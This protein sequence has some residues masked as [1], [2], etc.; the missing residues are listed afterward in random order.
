LNVGPTYA[1]VASGKNVSKEHCLLIA[2]SFWNRKEGRVGGRNRNSL[3][4]TKI[5]YAG[6][7]VRTPGS[8]ETLTGFAM[9]T[10][11]NSRDG[12]VITRT[13]TAHVG[14]NLHD[15]SNSLMAHGRTDTIL[16]YWTMVSVQI[17]STDSKTRCSNK[18]TI[19]GRNLSVWHVLKLNALVS[20][21][22]EGSHGHPPSAYV[23]ARHGFAATLP[24]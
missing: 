8:E 18:S 16:I 13:N 9:A 7:S 6:I 10:A 2:N 17:R 20:A 23:M 21:I 3:S 19:G 4:L 12:N 5:E 22:N 15:L 24:V 14:A 1:L 11:N